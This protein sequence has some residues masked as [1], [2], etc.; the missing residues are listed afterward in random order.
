VGEASNTE[1]PHKKTG[2]YIPLYFEFFRNGIAAKIGAHAGWVLL[3]ISSHKNHKTGD[4]Y[5]S[6]K[7][8]A[9]ETGLSIQTVIRCKKVLRS[10]GYLDYRVTRMRNPDSGA[11]STREM[12]TIPDLRGVK[13]P[14]VNL[15]LG[16]LSNEDVGLDLHLIEQYT[17]TFPKDAVYLQAN[18]NSLKK[19]RIY[20]EL[21]KRAQESGKGPEDIYMF[22][23]LAT[24]NALQVY[25]AQYG[26]PFFAQVKGNLS[27]LVHFA[28]TMIDASEKLGVDYE[29]S[30]E[31]FMK[32][33][34]FRKKTKQLNFGIVPLLADEWV[35][36][37]K[38]S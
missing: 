32:W 26:K 9:H 28:N 30:I 6:N 34:K 20:P 24:I 31:R 1:R 17:Q 16:K 22:F 38:S 2:G 23:A 13:L 14:N 36:T 21:L 5:P 19:I 35:V 25:G 29:A 4:C 11:M 18:F 33:T 3:A 7:L 10:L 15:R 8:I 37:L 27:N 12:Y